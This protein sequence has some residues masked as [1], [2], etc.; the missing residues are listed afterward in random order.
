LDNKRFAYTEFRVSIEE[1]V[2]RH[3]D[4]PVRFERYGKEIRLS[5]SK[6]QVDREMTGFKLSCLN[7]EMRSRVSRG[8]LRRNR[9]IRS[10]T[11]A[12]TAYLP[13]SA[14]KGVFL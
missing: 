14:T 4:R 5:S 7:F 8:R 10:P 9:S 12:G 13:T 6:V 3:E 11:R 2:R 1:T